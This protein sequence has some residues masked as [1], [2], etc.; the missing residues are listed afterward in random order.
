M[1][2]IMYS[3]RWKIWK[4]TWNWLMRMSL[5]LLLNAG[6]SPRYNHAPAIDYRFRYKIK[7][8]D[9]LQR[10]HG[11]LRE[12]VKNIIFPDRKFC[13]ICTHDNRC[14]RNQIQ[15]VWTWRNSSCIIC[16][17]IKICNCKQQPYLLNTKKSHIV[18]CY[19]I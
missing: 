15:A 10:W 4:F 2:K 14:L 5:R 1:K 11:V 17:N 12:S 8:N 6:N 3:R 16:K 7:P 18:E 19:F 13:H 9:F